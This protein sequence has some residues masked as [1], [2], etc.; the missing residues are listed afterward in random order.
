MINTQFSKPLR[1]RAT[2]NIYWIPLFFLLIV[3]GLAGNYFKYP[4][5]LNV[6][7]LFGSIFAMLVLQLLGPARGIMAAAAIAGYTFILWNHP[8]AIIIMTAEVAVVAWLTNRY[9]MAL[10]LADTLYWLIV[11][12]P[13]LYLF[14]HIVM[15]TPNSSTLIVM[16]KQ[17]VNGIANALVARLIITGLLLRNKTVQISM[18]EII[19][20]L[21]AFFVLLP[22]LLMLAIVSRS[23][24]NEIDHSVRT[25]LLQHNRHVIQHLDDWIKGR[26]DAV[27]TLASLA[28]ILTP[29]DMQSRLE[30]TQASDHDFARI[31]L[32]DRNG[33]SVA[34]SP[35]LDELGVS[36]I[37]RSFAD[38]PF[39]PMLKKSL[40]PMLSEVVMGKVGIPR[41]R[42]LM[43]A[44]VVINNQYGG[45]VAGTLNFD[46]IKEMLESYSSQQ[47]L[48]YTLI[49][50]NGNIITTNH[51]DQKV[52]T[53]FV[54]EK[55]SLLSLEKGISQWI[56][57]LANNIS[58]ME[59][60]Q[61][62]SYIVESEV[63][64]PAE[65]RLIL[66]QPIAPFQ[67]TLYDRYSK[68]LVL[69]FALLL[70]VL[71]VAN[72]VGSRIAKTTEELC[73]L[74][75]DMPARI[76]LN[77]AIDWPESGVMET[78]QLIEN[79]RDMAN[80]LS[81]VFEETRN[82]NLV[83]ERQ[84]SERTCEL[85]QSM[86]A[87]E[88]ANLAKSR[89]LSVVAHEFHT[90]LGLLAIN[91]DILDRYWDRLSTAERLERHQQIRN[92]ARQMSQMVDSVLV[93]NRQDSSKF[94][95]V[96]VPLDVA[97]FSSNT[98]AEVHTVWGK[99][100]DFHLSISP[101]CGTI[102]SD[103]TL[104]RRLLENLLTNAFRFT[105]PG[106][107]VSLTIYRT[108]DNLL[109]EVKDS[110]IGIPKEEQQFI[111]DAFYRSSNVDARNGLGLG[112]SIVSEALQQLNGCISLVSMEGEGTTFRVELPI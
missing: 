1:G 67:K 92:A 31:G 57:A 89:F 53:P 23:D 72:Q 65:W 68:R 94:P 105:P 112:L 95:V 93:L 25:S 35:L 79:F 51:K 77:T 61:K 64:T 44:P 12:I 4:I 38:R 82:I 54:R 26:N 32:Q 46:R 55:G 27:S 3:A 107:S 78:G 63:G 71:A 18:R 2:P 59:R 20:N 81:A 9:K 17:A 86:E 49:D 76:S 28:S 58:I 104:Y 34:F 97:T 80:A 103:E 101:D 15:Q 108:T 8:Y 22:A 99:G 13:M 14:Y 36:N 29:A 85:Q 87:A 16:S 43:L 33:I 5:F 91:V 41:P 52:M 48:L 98:A 75:K 100:H 10:V 7:F 50:K 6:D 69:L 40:R 70:I 11:G 90:P 21:L 30:Q 39:I 110:G 37:G 84:V 73:N 24:F 102:I 83:L 45:F 62:S 74:T 19:T 42:V 106:K 47:N 60:W 56:P 88:T 96:A 111:F 109:I 66:E